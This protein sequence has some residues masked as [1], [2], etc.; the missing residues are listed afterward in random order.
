MGSLLLLLSACLLLF[1]PS[2]LLRAQCVGAYNAPYIA[3]DVNPGEEPEVVRARCKLI[4]A[5][6]KEDCQI[7]ADQDEHMLERVVATEGRQAA[8]AL[9]A[10]RRRRLKRCQASVKAAR[11]AYVDLR[12][13]G[14]GFSRAHA[15]A[16]WE[17]AAWGGGELYASVDRFS[18]WADSLNTDDDEE[19]EE[20]D[21]KAARAQERRE[22]MRE[23]AAVRNQW[24]Q[25]RALASDPRYPRQQ[26]APAQPAQPTQPAQPGAP[27]ESALL[28]AMS[29]ETEVRRQL[30]EALRELQA[31]E[32]EYDAD[33]GGDAAMEARVAALLENARELEAWLGEAKQRTR[34]AEAAAHRPRPRAHGKGGP[35][36]AQAH[37]RRQGDADVIR[38]L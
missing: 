15:G 35:Q 19:E 26:P 17:A 7:Q 2:S 11:E 36:R 32:A 1:G 30:L 16:W 37:T 28:A 27:R 24:L 14:W 20:D 34:A 22:R 25:L 21:D 31:A 29:A 8:A 33:G 38:E 6:L 9:G 5:Q 12:D 10:V 4:L 18:E 13:A 23:R 3:A